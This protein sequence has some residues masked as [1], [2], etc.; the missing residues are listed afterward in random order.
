MA[1]EATVAPRE[2]VRDRYGRFPATAPAFHTLV[3]FQAGH[4]DEAFSD[5]HY[6]R[7]PPSDSH[8]EHMA[9]WH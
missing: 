2:Y 8:R 9:R 3:G 1:I 7:G 4:V 6:R 5:H